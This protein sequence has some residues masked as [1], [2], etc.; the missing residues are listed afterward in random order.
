MKLQVSG[1]KATGSAVEGSQDFS[2]ALNAKAFHTL[3]ST[4][5]KDKFGAIV[6]EIC[7]NAYDAHIMAGTPDRPFFLGFPDRFDPE[8]IIRDYGPGISPSDMNDIYCRF[9]ES[10]KDQSNDVVGAFGLGSKTPFSYTDTFTVT[11][12][13]EGVKRIYTAYMDEGMPRLKLMAETETDEESGLS[14][15]IP[16]D[17][18]D[19]RSFEE[20][21]LR[22]LRFFETKPESNRSWNWPS[23]EIELDFDSVQFFKTQNY[24]MQGFFVLIGP[25]GYRI[26]KGIIQQY[27]RKKGI[28]LSAM[29]NHLLAMSEGRN[30]YY[31]TLDR[32]SAILNMPIGSVEVQPSRE[33]LHYTDTVCQNILDAIQKAELKVANETVKRIDS[34]YAESCSKFYNT[35]NELPTF[36][37]GT[38]AKINDFEDTYKPF[39][40]Y[41]NGSIGVKWDVDS[42][43]EDT[44]SAKYGHIEKRTE[45]VKTFPLIDIDTDY[46]GKV[47]YDHDGSELFASGMVYV[48]DDTYAYKSRILAHHRETGSKGK[49]FFLIPRS[50]QSVDDLIDYMGDYLDIVR[51]SSLDRTSIKSSNNG[52]LIKGRSWWNVGSI[53]KN[54]YVSNLTYNATFYSMGMSGVYDSSLNDIDEPTIVI[55]TFNN[56]LDC[57]DR[58]DFYEKITVAAALSDCGYKVIGIPRSANYDNDNL[59]EITN[60][61]KEHLDTLREY[62]KKNKDISSLELAY[63]FA[64][65][66]NEAIDN[67]FSI[68]GKSDK[69]NEKENNV[70]QD[71]DDIYTAFQLMNSQH[72][73]YHYRTMKDFKVVSDFIDEGDY[74]ATYEDV[75]ELFDYISSKIGKVYSPTK[76]IE[77]IKAIIDMR[78]LLQHYVSVS[79]SYH[80]IDFRF[81]EWLNTGFRVDPS[82]W[83]FELIEKA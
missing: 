63:N 80:R 44:S 52:G 67:L 58:E 20:A 42:L 16:V 6:R 48:K 69:E 17:Q 40:I 72:R 15:C 2:M 61:K 23:W 74:A 14:V 30:A 12:I 68:A 56:K 8:L 66:F 29:V 51:V 27:A 11:S 21:V 77:N 73:Y 32:H 46:A 1:T 34:A 24:N 26:D 70:F 75:D 19:I 25:V 18:S 37:R 38:L 81:D 39:T 71:V 83:L 13:H 33:G 62:L 59:T 22:E 49:V 55:R 78:K 35:V 57:S 64:R 43:I 5:Y 28:K 76:M 65:K 79:N 36:I 53:L 3:S 31:S 4:L 41:N 54:R 47:T 50:N 7:S 10:T 45:T 9:F 82:D 60:L